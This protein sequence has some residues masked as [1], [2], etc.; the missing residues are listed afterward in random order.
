MPFM[1]NSLKL[2]QLRKAKLAKPAAF[3]GAAIVVCLAVSIPVTLMF[4]YHTGTGAGGGWAIQTVPKLAFEEPLRM[5]Q[6]LAA[7]GLLES[8]SAVSGWGR[9]AEISPEGP[10]AIAFAFGLGAFALFTV[11]RLRWR[12]WCLHPVMFLVWNRY[13]TDKFAPAF[14]MGWFI[15]VAVTKYGGARVYQKLKPLMFGLIAGEILGALIPMIVGSIY[16]FASDGMPQKV[17]RIL[18]G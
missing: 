13:A 15:K 18:P 4:Q 8:S 11:A 5:K 3:C 9:L 6:R 14:L 10:C 12:W 2:L 7:Q 16:Y 17:F 1:A